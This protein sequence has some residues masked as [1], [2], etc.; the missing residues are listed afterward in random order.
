MGKSDGGSSG[1]SGG[2]GDDVTQIKLVTIG[3]SGVGKSWLLLRWATES[4]K[5][6]KTHSMFTVGI[7][8][9]MKT[10][11]IDEKKVKVQ[12]WDTAGQERFRTITTSYYRSS[13]GILLVYDIT[14]KNTFQN[15]R[16]WMS[17]IMQ[18]ADADVNKILIG[19][20]CDLH[21]RRAVTY[22][23]GEALAKEYKIPFYETSA[24]TDVNVD[25]AFM[26]IARAVKERIETEGTEDDAGAAGGGSSG[27]GAGKKSKN[28]K[29]RK[30]KADDEKPK[31]KG[32][33]C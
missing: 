26:H 4:D 6:T 23:E 32:G 25:Q 27:G 31:K 7:D 11:D 10:V 13:Q 19:N 33:C 21:L 22:A 15:V 18:H 12:V 1:G 8:F 29:G 3:D 2:G 28:K 24:M 9:K 14:D 5:F 16:S 17:N 20:K 30:I